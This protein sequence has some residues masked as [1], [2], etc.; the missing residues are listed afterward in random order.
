MKNCMDSCF[1]HLGR[2]QPVPIYSLTDRETGCGFVFHSAP[3]SLNRTIETTG[4]ANVIGGMAALHAYRQQVSK[5]AGLLLRKYGERES[6]SW[7]LMSYEV[8]QKLS[9]PHEQMLAPLY[10]VVEVS[11]QDAYRF[12]PFSRVYDRP[13]V[14]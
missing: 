1:S 8:G 6:M 12:Y 11:Y 3:H 5:C 10:Q 2:D 13:K 14:R 9:V 7:V 4:E